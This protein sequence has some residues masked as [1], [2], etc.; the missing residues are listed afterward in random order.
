M[1]ESIEYAGM[2]WALTRSR[3]HGSCALTGKPVIKGDRIYKA[4]EEGSMLMLAFSYDHMS[5]A[6]KRPRERSS[7]S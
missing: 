1:P 6:D 4:Q 7:S 3:S 5:K 2:T